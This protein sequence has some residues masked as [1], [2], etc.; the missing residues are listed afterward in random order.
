MRDPRIDP[1]VGDIVRSKGG[2]TRQVLKVWDG[3]IQPH[4]KYQTQR[5]RAKPT[6]RTT[7]SA[8][9]RLWCVRYKAAV[10]VTK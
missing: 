6:I 7:W 3:G 2:V 9:W 5:G 4:I 1:V 10:V 8:R